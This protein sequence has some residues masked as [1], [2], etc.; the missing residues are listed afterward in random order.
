MLITSKQ[1]SMTLA[2]PPVGTVTYN[3]VAQAVANAGYR[4]PP[5]KATAWA[6][7][8]YVT[9]PWHESHGQLCTK[10][11]HGVCVCVGGGEMV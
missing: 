7:Q 8:V 1:L 6:T 9:V 5:A 3:G 2:P 4:Q 11:E 10:H